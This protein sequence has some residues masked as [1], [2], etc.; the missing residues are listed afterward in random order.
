MHFTIVER[1]SI[2]SGM[3]KANMI[4]PF[5]IVKFETEKSAT[6]NVSKITIV[7]NQVQIYMYTFE[8]MKKFDFMMINFDQLLFSQGFRTCREVM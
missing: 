3:T 8:F 2:R 7:N 4:S 1:L 6:E 5:L